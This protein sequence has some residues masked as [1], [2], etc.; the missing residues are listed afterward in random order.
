MFTWYLY[1]SFATKLRVQGAGSERTSLSSPLGTSELPPG[2]QGK[3]APLQRRPWSL[4]CLLH[5]LPTN[6][7]RPEIGDRWSPR[8]RSL[9]EERRGAFA[10]FA[11]GRHRRQPP[12]LLPEAPDSNSAVEKQGNRIFLPTHA[13]VS[14]FGCEKCVFIIMKFEMY[15]HHCFQKFGAVSEPDQWLPWLPR[16]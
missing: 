2:G 15:S 7:P 11:P 9:P 12:V 5:G 16:V 8:P 4:W 10:A 1:E 3:N 6:S 14:S 13:A